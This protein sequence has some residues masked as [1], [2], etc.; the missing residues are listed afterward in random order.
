MIHMLLRSFTICTSLLISIFSVGQ[1]FS[2]SEFENEKDSV[3]RCEMGIESWNYYIKSDLD[4]LQLMGLKMINQD[5]MNLYAVGLRNLGSYQIRG[6]DIENGVDLLFQARE[7]F[8]R[9]GALVLLSESENELGNA[10][11]LMGKYDDASKQYLAS[12]FH[13]SISSD[14]TASYNGMLGFGKTLCAEGD[15][16]QGLLFVQKFLE[17]CLRDGKYESASDACGFLGMIA[18]NMGRIELM[19]AYYRR[20]AIYSS[21]S[22]SS[23]YR[24]NAL[25]N[26]AIDYFY[27]SEVD[28]SILLFKESLKIREEVGATRPIVESLFNLSVLY[29]EMGDFEEAKRYAE[30]GEALSSVRGIRSWQLDCLRLLLEIAEE[31]NDLKNIKSLQFDIE[32]IEKELKEMSTLDDEIINLAVQLT[33]LDEEPESQDDL[34]EII[35]VALVIIT[36]STLMYANRLNSI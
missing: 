33:S 34:W 11:F 18:G 16:A 10:F 9:D 22:S 3:L 1:N 20:G 26:K 29:I 5:S 32:R 2:F 13:G 23:A 19:S 30:Q 21:R 6:D 24:A 14:C 8:S 17:R 25:T 28:S 27:H 7:I 36:A 15:T 12:I 4:S 31:S 35:T